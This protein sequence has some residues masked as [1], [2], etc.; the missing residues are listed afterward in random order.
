M[1]WLAAQLRET[2]SCKPPARLIR[3]STLPSLQSAAALVPDASLVVNAT[4]LGSQDM[5]EASESLAYPIRG[6]TVLVHAPRFRDMNTA[7]C[8]S[9]IGS[10]GASYVIPRARSGF[11]ILGGTFHARVSNPLTPDPA[12]TERI[13]KDAVLLAPELLPDNVDAHDPNAWKSVEVVGVNIGVRPAREGGARVEL[14]SKPVYVG[15]RPVGVIHAYGIGMCISVFSQKP[16]LH[17]LQDQRATK[18]VTV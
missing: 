15:H 13:L 1:H 12:V 14:D 10:G 7:H 4:G 3:V 8:I 17:L 18:Q 2:D 11:V 6:Q 5:P 16:F 9:K